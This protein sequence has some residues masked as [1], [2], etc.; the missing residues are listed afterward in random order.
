MQANRLGS[1]EGTMGPHVGRLV[2]SSVSGRS[3]AH[4]RSPLQVLGLD[5]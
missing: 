2:G 5:L 4:A 3:W 1:L